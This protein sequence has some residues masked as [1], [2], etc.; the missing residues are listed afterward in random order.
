VVT[1]ALMIGIPY[2]VAVQSDKEWLEEMQIQQT[3]EQMNQVCSRTLLH[4]FVP[5]INDFCS[6][7]LLRLLQ[8]P[9]NKSNDPPT[10]LIDLS[11]STG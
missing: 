1:A 4:S 3:M 6:T 10:L 2:S 5:L 7:W 11:G 8:G 9:N